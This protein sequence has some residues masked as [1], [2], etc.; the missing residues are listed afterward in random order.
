MV[1]Y[2]Q[3]ARKT[4]T[5]STPRPARDVEKNSYKANITITKRPL[6]QFFSTTWSSSHNR[7]ARPDVDG[8]RVVECF[9][10][11]LDHAGHR[12]SRAEFE[13]N[14]AAK[15]SDLRFLED[16]APLLA[17]GSPWDIED[18]AR[19]TRRVAGP[20]AWRCVERRGPE[21]EQEK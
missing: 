18:A 7:N 9:R 6:P 10:R 14:L 20:F 8:D 2:R 15:L 21:T 3:F 5:K 13:A 11:Y 1:I 19:Y 4:L 12:V 17:P 16:V